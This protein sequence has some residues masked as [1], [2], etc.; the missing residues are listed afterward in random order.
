MVQVH[1]V[2][3]LKVFYYFQPKEGEISFMEP[4]AWFKEKYVDV[5]EMYK[6]KMIL[7]DSTIPVPEKKYM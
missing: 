6:G 1:I 5:F 7:H 2:Y 4:L 3:D